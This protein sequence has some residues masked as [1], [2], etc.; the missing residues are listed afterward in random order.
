MDTDT[1]AV[2]VTLGVVALVV[3]LYGASR[4]LA[5]R[6]AQWGASRAREVSA[7]W[8]REA[9][10]QVDLLLERY[11]PPRVAWTD[12]I[13]WGAHGRWKRI[14]VSDRPM[15]PLEDVVEYRIPEDRYQELSRFPHGLRLYPE[16]GEIGARSDRESLNILAL[17]LADDIVAGR[18]TPEQASRFYLTTTRL[19][20]AGK[21]S[22]YLD[23]LLFKVAGEPVER[24][25]NMAY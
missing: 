13:E 19:A 6:A 11:G 8:P 17:N 2:A 16:T 10:L 23:R 14:V 18:R 15:S 12:R 21:S 22:P 5:P 3:S 4:I 20:A 25:A 24:I 9:R 7:R 1:K